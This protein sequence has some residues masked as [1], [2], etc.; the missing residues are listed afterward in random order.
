MRVLRIEVRSPFDGSRHS[1]VVAVAALDL[2]QYARP[3]SLGMDVAS[4][5]M[6]A[7]GLCL[8]TTSAALITLGGTTTRTAKR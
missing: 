5:R 8:D 3:L 1:V 2:M 7:A 4:Y 6:V